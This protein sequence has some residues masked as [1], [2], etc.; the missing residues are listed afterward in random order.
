MLSR[1]SRD[2][3]FV[4]LWTVAHQAPLSMGFSSLLRLPPT[5]PSS[6]P[7]KSSQ[8]TK[9]NSLCDTYSRFPLSILH[10]VVCM[11]QCH[12]LSLSHPLLPVLY[13]QV[14]ALYLCLYSWPANRP[15]STVFLDSVYRW[16]LMSISV[17]AFYSSPKPCLYLQDDIL[18]K[19]V[20]SHQ[21]NKNKN[22]GASSLWIAPLGAPCSVSGLVKPAG[23]IELAEASREFSQPSQGQCNYPVE[24][25]TSPG[26]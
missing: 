15:I 11:C 17:L 3:L 6:H 19:E 9:L 21:K 18:T 4:T 12:S 16:S 1:F 20:H 14:C 23:L 25:G 7:S 13:P 10:M 26:F 24:R 2:R 5:P 22:R 8:S